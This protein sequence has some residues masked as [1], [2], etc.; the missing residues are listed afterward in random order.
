M[1]SYV[2]KVQL[3]KKVTTV[4]ELIDYWPGLEIPEVSYSILRA[5]FDDDPRTYTL[6]KLDYFRG[7]FFQL[8]EAIGV[9]LSFHPHAVKA[10]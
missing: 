4:S 1:T 10:Y 5:K 7:K 8:S 9:C 2:E 6:E 3:F